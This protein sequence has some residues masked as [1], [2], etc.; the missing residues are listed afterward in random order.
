MFKI[1]LFTFT[2]LYLLL[3]VCFAHHQAVAQLS[4]VVL[5]ERDEPLPHA[6]VYVRNSTKGVNANANGEFRLPLD[7]GYH[8]IVFQYMGYRQHIEVVEI[9][10][11]PVSLT[12]RMVPNNVE[13]AEVEITS[14]DPAYRIMREA[15]AKRR[16]HRDMLPDHRCEV[17][18]KGFYK[19]IDTPKKILGQDIGNLGGILD[20]STRSGV[21]YLSESVSQLFVKKNPP[22]R[23]EVM[24]SSKVSGRD[25]GFSFNRSTYTDFNLYDE[26]IE[27]ERNILSP[28]ADNAF[29]YYRFKLK[30]RYTDA[31]NFDIYRIEVIPKRAEDPVLGGMIYVVDSWWNLAG[32]DLW[33]TGNSIKQP[34][35]DS[36]F[37][38]QEFVPLQGQ[39]QNRWVVLSQLAEFRFG[40]LGIKVRGFFNSIFSDYDFKSEA[41]NAANLKRREQF[42]IESEANKREMDYWADIRPIPLTEEEERDYTRKDSLQRIWESKAHLDSMDRRNNRFKPTSLL[43][44]YTWR[45]SYKNI[46]LNWPQALEWIRFNPMQGWVTDIRPE[47]ERFDGPNRRRSRFWRIAGN[48]N[49]GFSEKRARA[50]VSLQRRFESVHYR[51]L[52]L[53]GGARTEHFNRREPISAQLN[54]AYALWG[55][56]NYFRLFENTFAGLSWSQRMPGLLLRAEADWE[57][58]APMFT[59]SDFTW[60]GGDDRSYGLNIP[61]P[62]WPVASEYFIPHAALLAR[63]ALRLRI[64]ETY[65]SYPHFRAYENGAWPDI[66]IRYVKALPLDNFAP[67]YDH[68]QL[69]LVQT[70]ISLGLLGRLDWRARAG[71]FLRNRRVTYMDRYQPIG[72]ETFVAQTNRYLDA[73]MLMPFYGYGTDG[74]YAEGHLQHHLQGWLLD[75]IPLLNKL[76]WEEVVGLRAYYADRGGFFLEQEGSAEP[77]WEASWGFDN[78]GFKAFRPFRI[79]AAAAFNGRAYASWGIRLGMKLR[80]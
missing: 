7:K 9:G 58:R 68:L 36:L 23:K 43:F 19:L 56:R 69:E 24:I 8:E 33:L 12:V 77:Y 60:Y 73:F 30:G 52:T 16:Q 20:D 45:N 44:G 62:Q 10:A 31:N 61:E 50:W 1:A 59:R 11:A 35:L 25:N 38:R 70:D 3:C 27:V 76:N 63:A 80:G 14:E 57:R 28:L 74:A 29:A 32:A 4:G 13:L 54:T 51:T 72:N 67:D 2:H 55:Q 5:D 39:G 41:A 75:K 78:I 21:L 46:R 66:W 6:S 42:K 26:Y 15:I 34:A 18:I 40:I 22:E 49:Y 47:F 71:A 79:D 37:I 17:Y 64:G 53:R 65:N 48:L